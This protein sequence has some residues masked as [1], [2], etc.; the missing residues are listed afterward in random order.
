LEGKFVPPE[1]M[2]YEIQG[3]FFFGAADKLE[4]ALTEGKGEPRVLILRMR[5]VISMDATGLNALEDLYE[6]LRKHRKH[7]VL[8]VPNA[9][10]REVMENAGFINEIGR[11]NVHPNVTAALERA[12]QVLRTLS[13]ERHHR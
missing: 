3:S 10:P 11:E 8:S 12:K 7:L 2:I 1:V 13:E 5:R 4:S 6:K 9:Q